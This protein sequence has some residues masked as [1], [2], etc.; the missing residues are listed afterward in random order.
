MRPSPL[1]PAD[2]QVGPE[3]Q[4]AVRAERFLELP[5]GGRGVTGAAVGAAMAGLRP[6]VAAPLDFDAGAPAMRHAADLHFLSGGVVAVPVVFRAAIG[7]DPSSGVPNGPAME[8][9]LSGLPGLKIVLPSTPRDARGLLK[10]AIRDDN[11][12]LFCEHCQLYDTRGE[13]PEEEE[14]IPIGVADVKRAGRDVSIVACGAMVERALAAAAILAGEGIEPEVLDLRGTLPLDEE[15]ILASVARTG[16][17]VIVQ[18]G[19]GPCGVASDVAA[20]V[21]EKGL[22]HLDAPIRRVSARWTPSPFA[23]EL[24]RAL[25]PQTGQIA[26]AARAVIAGE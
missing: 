6:V 15:A 23:A 1:D 8:G 17:L 18:E 3:L 25:I 9:W 20:L 4:D 10:S 14:V 21:A 22:Y 26:D 2:R 11:P 24:R 13:V 7:G 19:A 16:R 12:V 5:V